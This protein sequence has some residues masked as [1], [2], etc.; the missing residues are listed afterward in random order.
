[1]PSQ[2]T[3][4]E[5]YWLRVIDGDEPI[6]PPPLAVK[7]RVVPVIHEASR[8]IVNCL[9]AKTDGLGSVKSAEPGEANPFELAK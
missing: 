8:S 1:M 4:I 2:N 7:T 5:E 6:L 3:E 9:P